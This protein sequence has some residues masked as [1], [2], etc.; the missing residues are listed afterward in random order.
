[1]FKKTPKVNDVVDH[2]EKVKTTDHHEEVNLN[3]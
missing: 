3:S 2:V 1:M